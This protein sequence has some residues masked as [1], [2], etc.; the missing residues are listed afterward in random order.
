MRGACVLLAARLYQRKT[1]WFLFFNN[2]I[3]SSA[4]RVSESTILI[5]WQ[6]ADKSICFHAAVTPINVN[7]LRW[8]SDRLRSGLFA[9]SVISRGSA[10]NSFEQL[11]TGML[12]HLTRV[13][14]HVDF[15]KQCSAVQSAN[16]SRMEVSYAR[17]VR[18]DWRGLEVRSWTN[19]K[20]IGWN[21]SDLNVTSSPRQSRWNFCFL[22]KRREVSR[23]DTIV[24][25]ARNCE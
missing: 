2:F 5:R 23:R 6:T 22:S 16:P 4:G 12:R 17:D 15:L 9:G 3:F 8:K 18:G 21:P 10:S 20:S 1:V 13:Q 11:R 19:D 24:I 7:G 14:R 25:I